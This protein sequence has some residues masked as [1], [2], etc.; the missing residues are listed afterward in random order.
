MWEEG[1]ESA[2]KGLVILRTYRYFSVV[3]VNFLFMSQHS[4]TTMILADAVRDTLQQSNHKLTYL[5]FKCTCDLVFN[6]IMQQF[7]RLSS[8]CPMLLLFSLC[9]YKEMICNKRKR[10]WERDA[11]LHFHTFFSSCK[12]DM[13]SIEYWHLFQLCLQRQSTV[14]EQI[15]QALFKEQRGRHQHTT[16][17]RKTVYRNINTPDLPV[18]LAEKMYFMC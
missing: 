16:S 15:Q 11:Y 3:T 8:W 9:K 13:D 12:I 7:Y 1:W 14:Y 2:M 17:I 5:H 6:W 4:R 18:E 10:A